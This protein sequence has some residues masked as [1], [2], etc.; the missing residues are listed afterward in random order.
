MVQNIADCVRIRTV[1]IQINESN[2]EMIM[3]SYTIRPEA[4]KSALVLL[5]TRL[6]HG[7][8]GVR[9]LRLKYS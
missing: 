3:T 8:D 5:V 9:N 2:L 4:N 7:P 6:F 1:Y